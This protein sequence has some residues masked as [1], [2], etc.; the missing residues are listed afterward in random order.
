MVTIGV[1]VPVTLVVGVSVAAG[2]AVVALLV[3]EPL[4]PVPELL[5]PLLALAAWRTNT[6]S[7]KQRL[8]L[9]T[10]LFSG[11]TTILPLA[12]A[13]LLVL[14]TRRTRDAVDAAD[15]ALPLPKHWAKTVTRAPTPSPATAVPGVVP[16]PLVPPEPDPPVAVPVGIGV[17]VD[18]LLLELLLELLV[19]ELLLPVLAVVLWLPRS[20]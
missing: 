19:D 15:A 4:V 1:S 17:A 2:A 10:L 3:A 9:A 20:T 14:V 8:P 5:V 16:D 13:F 18:E 12:L 6:K 7:A 11:C